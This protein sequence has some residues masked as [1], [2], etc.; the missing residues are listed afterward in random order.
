[1]AVVAPVL[2]ENHEHMSLI[3]VCISVDILWGAHIFD[4]HAVIL[5]SLDYWA[6]LPWLPSV[7]TTQNIVIR[8]GWVGT[9]LAGL[10][11]HMMVAGHA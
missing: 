2:M 9:G 5:S 8:P 4:H 10:I 7:G 6:L 11:L 3:S 1:M